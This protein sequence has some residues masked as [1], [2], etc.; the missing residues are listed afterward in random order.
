MEY[1]LF[2]SGYNLCIFFFEGY[3]DDS[4][5]SKEMKKISQ[6]SRIILE[7]LHNA[8]LEK[9]GDL[10]STKE[11]WDRLHMLFGASYNISDEDIEKSNKN[12]KKKK[13]SK[14][15]N[16]SVEPIV[17][18]EKRFEDINHNDLILSYIFYSKHDNSLNLVSEEKYDGLYIL[19]KAKYEYALVVV[20]ELSNEI[21]RLSDACKEHGK[22]L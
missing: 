16:A 3:C 6:A 18:K 19:F 21:G 15:S 17:Q 14:K 11:V 7:N 5:S 22:K 20:E 1:K 4:P 8:D 10:K 2:S 9:V 13:K 12:K